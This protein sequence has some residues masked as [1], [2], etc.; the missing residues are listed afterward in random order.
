MR[1]LPYFVVLLTCI[2]TYSTVS[3]ENWTRFRGPNG[4]GISSEKNLPTEWSAEKNVAWKTAIPGTAWSSPIVYKRS[5]IL[6]HGNRGRRIV[7]RPVC[8]SQKW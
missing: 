4:Q 6:D 2:A 1:V 7:P 5:H 3:A 8:R